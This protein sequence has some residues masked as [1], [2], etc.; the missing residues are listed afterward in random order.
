MGNDVHRMKYLAILIISFQFISFTTFAQ[1]KLKVDVIIENH[2]QYLILTYKGQKGD[3]FYLSK[4]F[5][6]SNRRLDTTQ[7]SDIEQKKTY[8]PQY[9]NSAL[10]I[11][12]DTSAYLYQYDEESNGIDS[13]DYRLIEKYIEDKGYYYAG[14]GNSK[15]K[16]K[17]KIP[18]WINPKILA[19]KP[20]EA[21]FYLKVKFDQQSVTKEIVLF[22][23]CKIKYR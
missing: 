10:Y 15:K 16:Y 22:D 21:I 13:T 4:D 3:I 8:L 5:A 7:L 19:T 23:T 2:S 20:E 17:Y 9:Y 18:I 11:L 1:R 14:G 6:N 12:N